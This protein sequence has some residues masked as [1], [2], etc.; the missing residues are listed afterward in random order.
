MWPLTP[1][2]SSLSK[3]TDAR[4]MLEQ[5]LIIQ[6]EWNVI[7]VYPWEPRVGVRTQ[8]RFCKTTNC[9]LNWALKVEK[10]S[11]INMY[12]IVLRSALPCA[13]YKGDSP[14][15]TFPE[16]KYRLHS[17]TFS[18][19]TGVLSC[20]SLRPGYRTCYQESHLWPRKQCEC[21]P[22]GTGLCLG[23]LQQLRPK[24]SRRQTRR[25][26]ERGEG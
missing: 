18:A 9:H 8:E 14:S 21:W 2:K 23:R 24:D 20:P 7:E 13:E 22:W 26:R 15:T 12:Q 17:G 19:G 25:G 1:R 11:A 6:C 5:M 4:P 3:R 16:M 10:K